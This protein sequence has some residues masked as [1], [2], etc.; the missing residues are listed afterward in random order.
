M[1]F[2][3]QFLTRDQAI[4]EA[5]STIHYRI[6]DPLTYASNIKDPELSGL[7]QL[8]YAIAVKRMQDK[9][10][11]DFIGVKKSQVELEIQ[12]ELNAVTLGWGIEVSS[13]E[14]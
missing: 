1:H 9:G 6:S 5:G 11:K 14:M 8:A 12:K 4:V 10:E 3:P 7:K 2:P 13:V